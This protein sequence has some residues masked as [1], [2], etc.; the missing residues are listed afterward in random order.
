[1]VSITKAGCTEFVANH[2]NSGIDSRLSKL[3]F[4][5]RKHLIYRDIKPENCLIGRLSKHN[6]NIIHIVDFGLAKMY[7]DPET[8]RHVNYA[9]NKNLT[10]TV[11]YMSVNAHQVNIFCSVNKRILFHSVE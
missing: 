5:H 2:C 4:F 9:E 1:M 8:G 7:I 11:R 6:S 3:S 10:G